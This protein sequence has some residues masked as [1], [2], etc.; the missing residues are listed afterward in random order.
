MRRVVIFGPGASGKTTFAAQLSRFTG[1]PHIELDKLF[2]QP[3]LVAMPRRS[4]VE[5][6]R[7][8][9]ARDEWILDGDLGPYDAAEER[10][11]AADTVILLDFSPLLCMRRALRRPPE[12]FDFWLWLLR[13]RSVYRPLLRKAIATHS[14]DAE[15]HILRSPKAIADFLKSKGAA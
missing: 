14:R 15:V 11:R 1:L 4:W 5:V 8:L 6:Q 9:V 2:W 12:R 10:L 3:G 13:Y 7:Q